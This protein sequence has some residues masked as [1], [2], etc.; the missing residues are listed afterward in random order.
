MFKK[1][2][3]RIPGKSLING[4][5]T[6]GLGLPDYDLALKQ[7]KNYIEALK[8]CGLEVIILQ[9]NEKYPDSTFVEDV[10]LLTKECAI[11]TNPGA[12]SRRGETTEIKIVLK[13]HYSNIEEIKGPGTVEAGDIMMVDSH[14]YIG[15]SER[16]N[17]EGANQ[18]ER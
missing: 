7:H 2:I 16:T 5:S 14:F 17:E 18:K 1:A 4:L 15:L 11:I 12:L 10:A 3:V 8:K 9:P 6:A 13:D